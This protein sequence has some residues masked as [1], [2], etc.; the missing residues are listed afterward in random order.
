[1]KNIPY[2]FVFGDEVGKERGI[3]LGIVSFL[4]EVD[5]VHLSCFYLCRSVVWVH[6]QL[7]D[8]ANVKFEDH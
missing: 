4:L 1:M 3:D 6:L 7:V 8:I 2:I 5:P